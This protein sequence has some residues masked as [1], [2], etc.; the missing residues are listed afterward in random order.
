MIKK[1]CDKRDVFSYVLTKIIP[2][3]KKKKPNVRLEYRERCRS[4][5]RPVIENTMFCTYGARDNAKARVS[6]SLW[7][8]RSRRVPGT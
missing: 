7:T 6:F 5:E 2:L 8:R 3:S 1:E 4:I